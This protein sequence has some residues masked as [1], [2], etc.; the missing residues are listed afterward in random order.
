VVYDGS[1][2]PADN[3]EHRTFTAGVLRFEPAAD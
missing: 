2:H 1:R 3:A